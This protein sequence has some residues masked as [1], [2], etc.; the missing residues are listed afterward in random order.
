MTNSLVSEERFPENA[1]VSFW[2]YT[3]HTPSDLLREGHVI[4]LCSPEGLTSKINLTLAPLAEQSSLG[5][6]EVAV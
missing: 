5:A 4:V 1:Y 6:K 2:S 3:L